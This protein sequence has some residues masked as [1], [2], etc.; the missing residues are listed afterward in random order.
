M[1]FTQSIDI[2]L[3]SF[4]REHRFPKADKGVQRRKRPFNVAPGVGVTSEERFNHM[5]NCKEV[6]AYGYYTYF[7][8]NLSDSIYGRSYCGF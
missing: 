8:L 5:Q 4:F 3:M 7:L 6:L 1:A 2:T